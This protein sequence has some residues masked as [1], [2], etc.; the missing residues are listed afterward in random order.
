MIITECSFVLDAKTGRGGG[1]DI[2]KNVY[3]NLSRT[4]T[5]THNGYNQ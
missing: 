1:R 2:E 5:I 3:V 4:K